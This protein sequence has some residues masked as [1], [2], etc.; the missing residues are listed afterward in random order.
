MNNLF[1]IVL[2]Y[3]IQIFLLSRRICNRDWPQKIENI[4]GKIREAL[5]DMPEHPDMKQ[6]LQT[7]NINYFTCQKIVEILKVLFWVFY[8][9][10][11]S[12]SSFNVVKY[13]VFFL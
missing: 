12:D 1:L 5:L 3:D 7:S 10:C 4:R 8:I 13:F 6:L 11:L 2:Q 9:Y